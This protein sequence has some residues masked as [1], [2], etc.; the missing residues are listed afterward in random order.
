MLG[1]R[2]IDKAR[3]QILTKGLKQFSA[4]WD[5]QTG[6]TG[7]LWLTVA[8]QKVSDMMWCLW[9]KLYRLTLWVA[10]FYGLPCCTG[11]NFDGNAPIFYFELSTYRFPWESMRDR[12]ATLGISAFEGRQRAGLST[13]HNWGRY[14]PSLVRNSKEERVGY[15]R[16]QVDFP[17]SLTCIG[18]IDERKADQQACLRPLRDGTHTYI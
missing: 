16:I 18:H 17:C 1:F 9:S 10:S 11:L 2:S 6:D 12:S 7:I 4:V 14:F 15:L 13:K 5:L 8:A 3:A